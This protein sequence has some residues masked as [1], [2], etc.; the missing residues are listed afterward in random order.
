M[1]MNCLCNALAVVIVV[2][3][4]KGIMHTLANFVKCSVIIKIC[5]YPIVGSTCKESM[6]TISKGLDVWVGMSGAL[7][8]KVVRQVHRLQS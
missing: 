2:S 1:L 5:S 7:M 6:H 4:L 8:V 3:F